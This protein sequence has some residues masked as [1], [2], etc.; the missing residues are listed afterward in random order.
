V[1]AQRTPSLSTPIPVAV[2][3]KGL[4]VGCPI[5]RASDEHC[6]IVR[7]LRAHE[8]VLPLHPFPSFFLFPIWHVVT[9][10]VALTWEPVRPQR[11]PYTGRG[12]RTDGLV[13]NRTHFFIFPSL[14]RPV[15]Y[16]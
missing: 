14:S 13:S 2:N 7:V 3:S 15:S 4:S 6:F 5:V 11:G 8:T 10:R 1:R 9:W 12:A 16:F